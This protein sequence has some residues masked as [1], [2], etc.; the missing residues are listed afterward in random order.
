ML[1]Q[2]W[3]WYK[4]L[5]QTNTGL[6]DKWID[7]G[8]TFAAKQSTNIL[9][10]PIK[11]MEVQIS[12]R[13]LCKVNSSHNS[14]LSDGGTLFLEVISISIVL[15]CRQKSQTDMWKQININRHQQREVRKYV[16]LICN[17]YPYKHASTI[18]VTVTILTPLTAS[19]VIW[20]ILKITLSF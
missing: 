9:W 12:C 5:W 4:G 15:G 8:S 13:F 2:W 19:I 17:S 18:N 3:C 20:Y 16:F 7:P 11:H 1:A 6:S 10:L 14:I